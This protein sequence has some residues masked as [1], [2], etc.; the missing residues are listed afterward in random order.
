MTIRAASVLEIDHPIHLQHIRL[1]RSLSYSIPHAGPVCP[2]FYCWP[3]IEKLQ[4]NQIYYAYSMSKQQQ[5]IKKW[6]YNYIKLLNIY[7]DG[8]YS[9]VSECLISNFNSY[10]TE[11]TFSR[12]AKKQDV[13]LIAKGRYTTLTAI[14]VAPIPLHEV[15]R[16]EKA[17]RDNKIKT[18]M[19][20]LLLQEMPSRIG[21]RTL[22]QGI[23][24]DRLTKREL[25]STQGYV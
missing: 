19:A 12:K 23:L 8:K 5:A 10:H 24:R 18:T 14:F 16:Q 22:Q 7:K 17:V 15:S 4:Q 21:T 9:N 2:E 6:Q 11:G 13:A 25:P 20:S 1:L 3:P